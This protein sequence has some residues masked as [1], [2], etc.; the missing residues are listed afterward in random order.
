[1]SEVEYNNLIFVISRRLQELNV[2]EQLLFMCRGKLANYSDDNI[3]DV[4][5]LFKKLEEQNYLGTDRLEVIKDL[6]KGVEEWPLLEKV[7]KFES[8]RKEY[9]SLLEQIIRA[10]DQLND[11]ERLI[12]M[13]RG[14]MPEANEGNIHDVRSLFK[15]LENHSCLGVNRMG[16]VKEILIEI[17]KEDLL[18]EVEE[19]EKRIDE[20]EEF[21]RRKGKM[22]SCFPVCGFLVLKILGCRLSQSNIRLF[23]YR[24]FDWISILVAY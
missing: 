11:L 15:V 9:L 19:F 16:I 14:K 3:Q 24:I 23:L 1:M 2:L 22:S 18:K 20:D 7:K 12:T 10:L 21:E 13:C 5:S 4:L 8:K 6:L 17:E